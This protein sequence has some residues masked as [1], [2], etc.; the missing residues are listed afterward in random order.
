M[1]V[2]LPNSI[3]YEDLRTMKF[4]LIVLKN[5]IAYLSADE[6]K[7]AKDALNKNGLLI[8]NAFSKA[9]EVK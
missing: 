2:R 5:A 7:L 4:D 9:P 3:T 6:L 1:N 8:A